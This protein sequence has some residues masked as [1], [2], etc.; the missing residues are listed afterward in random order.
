MVNS[1]VFYDKDLHHSDIA[2]LELAYFS[3]LYSRAPSQAHRRMA[4]T[5]FSASTITDILI[6][7]INFLFNHHSDTSLQAI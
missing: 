2:R 5:S 1:V 3:A 6:S 4:A 7:N